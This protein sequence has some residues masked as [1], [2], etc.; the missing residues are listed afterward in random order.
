[1]FVYLF[2][3]FDP[4]P[5]KW[6]GIVMSSGVSWGVLFVDS[7]KV[8]HPTLSLWARPGGEIIAVQTLKLG[9][10]DVP[11]VE[12]IYFVFTHM[13]GESYCRQLK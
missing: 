2:R 3:F 13:S 4:P 5:P 11:L 6:W 1:M 8:R 12:F 10:L 9:V 7:W